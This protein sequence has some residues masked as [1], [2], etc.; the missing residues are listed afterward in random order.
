MQS[1]VARIRTPG[2][3]VVSGVLIDVCGCYDTPNRSGNC[4]CCCPPGFA[5]RRGK[6][7]Y[8]CCH[9]RHPPNNDDDD[10]RIVVVTFFA[11]KDT[12]WQPGVLDWF[13]FMLRKLKATWARGALPRILGR[14]WIWHL[15][16]GMVDFLFRICSAKRRHAIQDLRGSSYFV[17]G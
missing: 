2:R 3:F 5:K 15:Q 9:R 4:C 1:T 16:N 13:F 11:S 6:V 14:L 7:P 10:F 17:L 8:N 12:R